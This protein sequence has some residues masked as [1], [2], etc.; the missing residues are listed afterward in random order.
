M[1]SWGF[2]I[3][4]A[5]FF[6]ASLNSIYT[7]I[8]IKIMGE[9][10]TSHAHEG[11]YTIEKRQRQ[12]AARCGGGSPHSKTLLAL[13]CTAV[14]PVCAPVGGHSAD[15]VLYSAHYSF[16]SS[17]SGLFLTLG[18]YLPPGDR[19]DKQFTFLFHL[20]Q[21]I[22]MLER[23][24]HGLKFPCVRKIIRSVET[25]MINQFMRQQC[26]IIL[27][28][29]CLGKEFYQCFN[30]FGYGKYIYKR[31]KLL[32]AKHLKLFVSWHPNAGFQV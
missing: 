26:G 22:I 23:V 28:D 25:G 6:A 4:W 15:P 17:S 16:E 7:K 8:S 32:G 12:I 13:V 19:H 20:Q 18:T 24:D 9:L 30:G 1:H 29:N 3:Q 31:N 10:P 21:H 11:I 27:V 2:L 5:Q 14:L